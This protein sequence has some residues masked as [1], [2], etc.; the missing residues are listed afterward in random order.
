MSSSSSFST[1]NGEYFLLPAFL[2][3]ILSLSLIPILP[4]LNRRYELN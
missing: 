2:W 1:C 4:S 3:S